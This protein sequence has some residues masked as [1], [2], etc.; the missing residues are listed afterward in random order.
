MRDLSC[1]SRLLECG[2]KT[3]E[4]RRLRGDQI[5]VLKIV[6]GYEDIDRNIFF[7]LKEGSRT[8]GH[9]A[10]LITEQCHTCIVKHTF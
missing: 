4:T 1:E 2:F 5:E 3:L 6:N 9:K 8:R 7:K 10:A